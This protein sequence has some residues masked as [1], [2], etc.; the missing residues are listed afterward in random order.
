M[1]TDAK[2]RL[3]PVWS[4]LLSVAFSV[5]AFLVCGYV[6]Y[7]VAVDRI[8]RFE[9][10]FRPL[11]ALV[12]FAIYLW[13]LTVANQVETNQVGAL[14]LGWGLGS[15]RQFFWGVLLGL[16]LT[17]VAVVPIL[18]WGKVVINLRLN[19]HSLPRILA[20]LTILLMG[21]LAEE[22]MFRGYPFQ[23]LIDAAGPALAIATFSI[24]FGSVHLMNP[25]ASIWGL[26]NTVAIGVVL[27]IA[28]LRTRALWFSWGIHFGWNFALGFL[29]GLPVSGLRLFNV[30]LRTTA[31]GPPWLTGGKYGAEA[32]ASGAAAVL[33]GLFIVWKVPVRPLN[34]AASE[35][36]ASGDLE[37]REPSSSLPRIQN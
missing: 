25:G 8:V 22:L 37:E 23:R 20:V 18:I 21:A 12:L 36:I 29:F 34:H 33:A 9:V 13:L 16:L 5:A 11:L 1:F 30:V 35:T 2:G 14:G 15:L 10:I 19:T 6:A 17:L 3:Q 31:T 28:Y 26:I 24:L 4:F 32:A 27:S 7:A